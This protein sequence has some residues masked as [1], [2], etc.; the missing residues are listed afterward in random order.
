MKILTMPQGSSEWA[1]AR[2]GVVTASEIGALVTPLWKVRTGD[3]PETYLHEK[4]CEK[5]LGWSP[6]D[7]G[8]FAM[9]QGQIVET[10]ARPWFQFTYDCEVKTVGFITSDDGKI[11]ASPDGLIG[12]DRGLEIKSPQPPTHLKYLLA[13][14]LPPIYAPQVQFSLY[15]TRRARWSFVSYSRHFPAL[16]VEVLPDPKAFAAFDEAL[17]LFFSKFDPALARLTAERDAE[18]A[19][20]EARPHQS[21]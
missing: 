3:G 8:S 1:T 13:G 15:I 5:F 10:I 19:R 16:V 12:D 4:L 7:A 17:T 2:L 11:G 20:Q 18:N 21:R 9:N 6:D 14:I